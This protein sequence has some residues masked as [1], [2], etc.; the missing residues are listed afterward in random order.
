MKFGLQLSY[1][2]ATHMHFL[3]NVKQLID[4]SFGESFFGPQSDW[5]FKSSGHLTLGIKPSFLFSL[6]SA[7]RVLSISE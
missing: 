2:Y 7:S 3:L 4:K 1:T 6:G 5:E